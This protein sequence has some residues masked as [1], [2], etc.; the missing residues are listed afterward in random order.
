M[1]TNWRLILTTSAG[2]AL[3]LM[4]LTLAGMFSPHAARQ[5]SQETVGQQAG[6]APKTAD[7]KP[8][9]QTTVARRPASSLLAQMPSA[10]EK[11]PT[12]AGKLQQSP[13][14]VVARQPREQHLTAAPAIRLAKRT[15]STEPKIHRDAAKVV[16]STGAKSPKVAQ[17]AVPETQPELAAQAFVKCDHNSE[18][19]LAQQLRSRIVEV[20]LKEHNSAKLLDQGESGESAKANSLFQVVDVQPELRGLVFQKAGNCRRELQSAKTLETC[21]FCL[22]ELLNQADRERAHYGGPHV[23]AIYCG[24]AIGQFAQNL[25][26][27]KCPAEAI[28][29]LAQVVPERQEPARFA[30]V[31]ELSRLKKDK[32]ARD[33]L[34]RLAIFDLSEVIRQEAVEALRD[35][36]RAEY[37]PVF[38]AG[39]RY[40]WPPVAEHAAEA[41]VALEDRAAVA[42]L[43][44]LLDEPDPAAPYIGEG[45]KWSMRELVAVNH[46]QN[47]LLCHAPSFSKD[48]PIRVRIPEPNKPL[49]TASLY[50]RDFRGP[51]VR[52]DIT[53][54]RQDFSVRQ[55][56]AD[57][58]VWPEYQRYD[59]LVRVREL[60]ELD[61]KRLDREGA[62][63]AAS[64]QAS[65]YPQREAVRF[66]LNHLR[67]K[68][69]AQS[70]TEGRRTDASSSDR[71]YDQ[72]GASF[73][74]VP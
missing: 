28:A 31:K 73:T 6:A 65:S 58:G 49:P 62:G 72:R 19:A 8:R 25:K 44:R 67:G 59:Y 68:R 22:R 35:Q 10:A 69:A 41:L 71:S 26:P 55:P 52:A 13:P 20:K 64:G 37:R 11:P 7:V 53:Y 30:L 27:E 14:A 1:V 48:D 54:L 24:K 23:A 70:R 40:P 5:A 74:A 9:P 42:D 32:R 45:N 4:L 36:P 60:S 3:F 38:L 15:T 33:A 57:H 46:M 56:V 18:E 16:T 43:T 47:C 21:A 50:D 61:Q 39:L 66:A 17:A 51:A 2:V 34:L 12:P 29:A 63:K